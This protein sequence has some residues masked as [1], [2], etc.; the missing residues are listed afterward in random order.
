LVVGSRARDGS[1]A[2]AARRSDEVVRNLR[3]V[4]ERAPAPAHAGSDTGGLPDDLL[5]RAGLP[6]GTRFAAALRGATATIDGATPMLEKNTDHDVDDGIYF[7]PDA[8]LAYANRA[9]VQGDSGTVAL[10]V[11]PVDWIG[12]DASVHSFFRVNDPSE[13][14]YRFHLLK[15]AAHLRF[16]FITER[17]ETNVRVPIEWW[18]RGEGHHVAATWGDERLRLYVDG[19]PLGEQP[20]EGTLNVTTAAPGWWGSIA[21]GGT[22]GAGAILK[23]TLVT[24]RPLDDAEIQQLWQK[25]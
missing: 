9:G 4:G 18:P 6:T 15:D 12:S 14:G 10:W 5:A 19:V 24:G 11:E 3:E 20:Y 7:P 8:Q 21:G 16:Q 25:D 17:G 13:G 2:D 23:D 22:P 1:D